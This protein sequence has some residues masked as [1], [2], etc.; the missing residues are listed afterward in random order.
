M[1]KSQRKQGIVLSYAAQAVHIL[2]GLLYTPVMLRLLGQSEYGIYQLV[3][4]VVAYLGLLSFGFSSAYVRFYSRFRVRENKEEIAQLNGMFMA[5]FLCIS[6][7]SVFCGSVML[8]NIDLIFA[9]SLTVLEYKTA[10]ILMALMVLNLT[11]TFPNS[12]FDAITSAQEKFIF[13]KTLA[14]LQAVFNPFITL[15]LLIAG[16]GSVGMV[17]V[18][19]GLTCAKLLVNIAYCMK[20]L[21]VQFC[22]RG[23]QFSL[24]KEM[25]AFTFFIFLNMIIDQIN[26]SVDKFLLG[27]LAGVGA[28]AVYGVASQLN[29]MYQQ[30][31][32]AVSGVYIPE[33]NRVVA[34]ENDTNRYL[35]QIFTKVGRIQFIIL[36]L[37]LS[38]FV[39]FGRPFIRIWAGAEYN[40][41]Y[42]VALLLLIPVTVPL[43]QNLGI[44]IQRA[45]NMHKARSVVYLFIAVGNVIVSIPCIK[46]WGVQGAALGTAISL[47]LGNMIFMN[48]YY[49]KRMG[50]NILYFWKE[51]LRLVPALIIP[52]IFGLFAVLFIKI[53]GLFMLVVCCLVYSVLFAISM[54]HLGLNDEE[55]RIAGQVLRIISL[56]KH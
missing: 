2:S 20:K 45:K 41:S 53:R 51:I 7:L 10:R 1:H 30:L 39:F 52:G 5:I 36:S 22:F 13:Q 47:V 48:Y 50:L 38:G 11:L 54:W 29:N 43:I 25:W 33:V 21:H 14:L 8:W 46:W 18:T 4:S 27:R 49:Q 56:H 34:E 6:T 32:T 40:E 23:L 17:M 9:E 19:T 35:T 37:V 31:S 44:A 28:V 42:E 3:S 15:P 12:V 55:K 26:W 24:L 16:A